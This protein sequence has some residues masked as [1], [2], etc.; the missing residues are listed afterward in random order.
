MS[1]T[2]LFLFVLLLIC[3]CQNSIAQGIND[4]PEIRNAYENIL[5]LKLAPGRAQ[6]E[7]LSNDQK[8]TSH[9]FYVKNLADVLELLITQ[10]RYIYK[11]YESNEERNLKGLRQIDE[12]DPYKLFY[13]SEIKL[14][15]A[16]VKVLFEEEMKAGLSIRSSFN[17]I[18]K[19]KKKFPN[20]ILN[21]KTL[22][23]FHILL[24]TLPDNAAW[25]F[26]LFG[27][28]A[29]LQLGLSELEKINADSPY[30]LE[31][32]LI[33]LLAFVNILNKRNESL[34]LIQ[35]LLKTHT[36]NLLL[37]Y[38]HSSTLIKYGKSKES[39]TLLT[40][41]QFPSKEYL[42][43]D[44]INYKLGEIY[45]QKQDYRIARNHYAL[46]LNNYRGKD[47]IKDSWFKIFLTYWLTDNES[48]ASV[49]FKKAQSSGRSF[50]DPDRN[51]R[52]ILN[53]EFYPNKRLMQLRLATDGGY[54]EL[55][56]GIANTISEKYFESKK[57]KTEYFYRLGR[58]NHKSGNLEDA[59]YYYLNTIK[60][61]ANERWYFAPNACLQTG[62]I[63]K[64][65]Q[66]FDKAEYYFNK[67]LSYKKHKYKSSID[68]KAEAALTEL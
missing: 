46:F 9:Y 44:Y 24:T 33:K 55:A 16:L 14:Q 51:A 30:Y 53:E 41:L 61:S 64:Q 22:G 12:N 25:V 28:K 54:F 67:S 68:R 5:K 15:W 34:Q 1:F 26:S 65:R 45:L 3:C 59:I 19:N 37:N 31:A 7:E 23:T 13:E 39:L 58:L 40:K 43:I 6:L 50:S 38:L 35:E 2:H 63:Y 48:M 47:L 62:Y 18:Q 8:R 66:Q 21:N 49:H 52:G 29:D 27:I 17:T 20:F 60:K 32:Q 4:S 36:D 42:F 11:R 57:D 10:D 56:T